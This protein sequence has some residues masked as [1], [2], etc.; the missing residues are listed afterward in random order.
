MSTAGSYPLQR[1]A[2]RLDIGSV[3]LMPMLA[4]LTLFVSVLGNGIDI[5]RVDDRAEGVTL[6]FQV[7]L[8][9]VATAAASVCGAW[10]WWRLAEVRAA[11]CTQRGVVAMTMVGCA[12][13]ASITSV[14]P[15]VAFFV[16]SAI[17]VYMLLTLTCLTLFGMRRMLM[18]ALM[19]LW[20]FVIISWLLRFTVP[21]LAVFNEYLSMEETLPRFGGLG[22]PNVLSAIQCLALLLTLA[23]VL[24]RRIN[25]WWLVPAFMLGAATLLE[26]KSRTSVVAFLVTLGGMSLPF[27]R[28][29]LA[30][31]LPCLGLAAAFCGAVFLETTSGI[32]RV[33]DALMVK[34]TKTG[35]VDELTTATG[36]TEIWAEAIRL[37]G[38][39]PLTGYGG[40]TSSQVMAEHSG[41]AHNLILEPSVLFGL[42]AAFCLIVLLCINVR[43]SYWNRTFFVRIFTTYLLVLGLVESP[44]FG[45]VPDP[46]MCIWMACIFGAVVGRPDLARQKSTTVAQTVTE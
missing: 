18:D 45:L 3:Q 15:K 19:A 10:A 41:H 20:S 7:I 40:G 43:E 37:I 11:L 14:S 12:L 6:S 1:L 23:F 34:L 36:R 16:A 21:E 31:V 39:S 4:R 32:D 5:A 46:M 38:K 44:L 24:D 22:H 8:R 42:P 29:R 9:L 26:T 35:T 30:F 28:Q 2:N 25:P 13:T 33:T 27:W 17:G